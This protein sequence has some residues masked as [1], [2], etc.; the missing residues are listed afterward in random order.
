MIKRI[1]LKVKFF[2][3]KRLIDVN[4]ARWELVATFKPMRKG[5]IKHHHH[6]H[7]HIYPTPSIF[8][9]YNC[10]FCQNSFYVKDLPEYKWRSAY[11]WT[12]FLNKVSVHHID[13]NGGEPMLYS[14]IVKL[15]NGLDN[16]NVVMFTNN[17]LPHLWEEMKKGNNNIM[18]CVSYHPLEEKRSIKQFADDFKMIPSYLKPTMHMI[19]IPEI[20]LKNIRGQFAYQGVFITGLDAIIP[21]KHNQIEEKFSTVMCDSGMVAIAPNMTVFDCPALMLRKIGGKS[22]DDYDWEAVMKKCDYYGLCGPICSSKI[23]EH[24][25][26]RIAEVKIYNG[27]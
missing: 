27:I 6:D 11:E 9:N 24:D 12:Q 17:P 26:K 22:I 18:I 19:N 7:I 21:T 8:C 20:S 14:Q 23:T 5:E 3:S 10:Y 13:I 4:K 2:I 1:K 25:F 15:M 16:H